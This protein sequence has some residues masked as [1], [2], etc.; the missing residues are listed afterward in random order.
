MVWRTEEAGR[1]LELYTELDTT[2][3]RRLEL[4]LLKRLPIEGQL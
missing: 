3:W 4:W 2:C 1:E